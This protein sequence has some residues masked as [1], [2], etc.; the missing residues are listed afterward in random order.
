MLCTM[1]FMKF[2]ILGIMKPTLSKK[3]QYINNQDKSLPPKNQ[4]FQPS[5]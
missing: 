3:L 4:Q 1:I 5:P 2:V